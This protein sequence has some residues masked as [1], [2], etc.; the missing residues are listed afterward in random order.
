MGFLQMRGVA[1]AITVGPLSASA[2]QRWAVCQVGGCCRGSGGRFQRLRQEPD[3]CTSSLWVQKQW[4]LLPVDRNLWRWAP[5]Q[6]TLKLTISQLFDYSHG[7]L[8]HQGVAAGRLCFEGKEIGLSTC[9]L[10]I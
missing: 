8:T 9:L 4:D 10:F 2:R 7:K 6:T 5:Q 1:T 3:E